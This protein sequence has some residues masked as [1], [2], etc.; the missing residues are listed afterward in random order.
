[1]KEGTHIPCRPMH[2]SRGSSIYVMFVLRADS[3]STKTNSRGAER[4]AVFFSKTVQ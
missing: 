1:M 2:K 3:W 4:D